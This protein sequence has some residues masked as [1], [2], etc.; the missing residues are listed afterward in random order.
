M[1][2]GSRG[3][4]KSARTSE[5]GWFSPLQEGHWSYIIRHFSLVIGSM[6]GQMTIEKMLNL[7]DQ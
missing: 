7:L 2:N 1:A 5:E 3:L 4:I 6:L